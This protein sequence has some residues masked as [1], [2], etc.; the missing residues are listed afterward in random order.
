MRKKGTNL[1]NSYQTKGVGGNSATLTTIASNT[2]GTPIHQ[3]GAAPL[4][5][6]HQ[7]SEIIPP[8]DRM[9]DQ[10]ILALIDVIRSA[11]INVKSA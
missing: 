8:R 1:R 6:N 7:M 2:A 10:R 5:R 9:V 4:V 11:P 3:E